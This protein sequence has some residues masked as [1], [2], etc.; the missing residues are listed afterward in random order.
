MA[1]F[2]PANGGNLAQ[3]LLLLTV[4]F[5]AV[6]NLSQLAINKSLRPASNFSRV[7]LPTARLYQDIMN[8]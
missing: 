3:T 6:T 5:R 1:V 4:L 7:S 8:A 2:K